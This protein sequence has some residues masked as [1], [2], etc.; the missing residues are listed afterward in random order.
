MSDQAMREVDTIFSIVNRYLREEI[1]SETFSGLQTMILA[2]TFSGFMYT[3]IFKPPVKL[4]T[5][6]VNV[7]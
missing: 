4:S 1:S 6:T 2:Q 7:C 5:V 3:T